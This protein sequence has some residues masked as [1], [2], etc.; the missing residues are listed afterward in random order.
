M[1]CSAERFWLAI[2]TFQGKTVFS[3]KP[4]MVNETRYEDLTFAGI[5]GAIISEGRYCEYILHLSSGDIS[6]RREMRRDGKYVG[7]S[8]VPYWFIEPTPAQ[9]VILSLII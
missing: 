1:I 3:D 2:D 8:V 4:Y 7:H 5:P 9:A 6:V